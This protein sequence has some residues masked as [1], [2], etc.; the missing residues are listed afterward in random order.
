MRLLW[1]LSAVTGGGALLLILNH[2][3]GSVFGIA[4]NDFASLIFYGLWGLLVGAAILPRPG[5]WREAARN[6]IAWLAI[7]LVLMAVYLY[8]FELQDIASRI[9]A[10][11]IPGSPISASSKDG[12]QQVSLLRTDDGHYIARG[13]ANG[14]VTGFLVDTGATIVVL[15]ESDAKSAGF[16]TGALSYDFPVDT[17]NGSTTAAQVS[18][19]SLEIGTIKRRDV[20]AMVARAGSLD[21]SLLGIEFPVDAS[22]F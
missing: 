11:I 10:G 18:L 3:S 7:I 16:D 4:Q 2:D 20:R 13:M 22:Q 5:Q 15:S 12:R 6:A 17:A 14:V 8:R 19:D 21:T 9:S 1:V